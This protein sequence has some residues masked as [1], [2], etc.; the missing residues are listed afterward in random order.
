VT[1]R[2]LERLTAPG[3]I[4]LVATGAAHAPMQAGVL[5]RLEAGG[6]EGPI[7]IV[8]P[9]GGRL[10]DRAAAARIEDLAERPDLGLVLT[11]P[12]E[13]PAAID[14][15]GRRGAR[16]AVVFTPTGGDPAL[17]Q[18]M[19]DAA[20]PHLLRILG[21]GSLGLQMP[22][23]G[24][25]ASFAHLTA[26]PGRIGLISQ[27]GAIAGAM[28]D[29][30]EARDIGF[31]AILAL[32]EMAD[33]DTGDLI[34][35]LAADPDTR[36]ILLYVEA[37]TDAR[38][39]LSAA[40]AAARTKPVIA[41]KARRG[42]GGDAVHDAAF[43]RA[44]IVRVAALEDLF[45]AAEALARQPPLSD[46]RLAILGN[47]GGAA[48]L[49]SDAL[50]AAGG[51]LAALSEET[52]ARLDA[53]LPPGAARSN[54]LDLGD[55]A[56]GARYADALA[57][58]LE[59][60]EADAILVMHFPTGVAPPREIADAVVA[61]HARAPR[62]W[63]PKPVF[64][65][66]LGEARAAEADP[67]LEGAGIPAY[68]TP[69]QAIGGFSHL[70]EHRKAQVALIRTPPAIPGEETPNRSA[71]A[72][73]V[74]QALRAGRSRLT[75]P[76]ARAVLRAYRIPSIET[77][78]AATAAE[79]EAA[80]AALLEAGARSLAVKIVAPGIASKT[81]L[82]GVR[83]DVTTA[84]EARAAAAEVLA[85]AGERRPD[86]CP[87]G[88]AVQPM[89]R[90]SDAI[91]LRAGLEEDPVFGPVVV[92]GTGGTAA[93][94]IGDRAVALPPLDLVLAEDLVSRA[95]VSRLIGGRPGAPAADREAIRLA[96][97]RL[98]QLAAD[99]PEITALDVNPL[100]AG[101]EGVLAL[102]IRIEVAPARPAE[103]GQ[104]PRFALRPYPSAWDRVEEVK[105]RRLRIR[106]IRPE[107]E[108]L[109]PD[110]FARLSAQDMRYRFFG[111]MGRPSHEQIARFTQIDYAR[112]MA[113]VALPAEG[114]EELL[115]V[116]RLATDPDGLEAEFAVIV[117]SDLH[118]RGLGGALMRRLIDYA[119]AEGIET[120]YG[121]V[122]DQ[123]RGMLA[124]CRAL[125]FRET[126]HP[127]DPE[128]QRVVMEFGG[129]GRA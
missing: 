77:R 52:L 36:A 14:A 38:K 68:R 5:A 128:L 34:D 105:G 54:P 78:I 39:F 76:E 11:P 16:A 124:M 87:E 51:R 73:A 23:L 60:K 26:R 27:S 89:A 110:F 106:P 116:S 108:T 22:R 94:A 29:W 99:M 109:Y 18:A 84:P 98:A 96:L 119:R 126:E 53:A 90:A 9:G 20:R 24:L 70:A 31:S 125:G 71:A 58:L 55:D 117:R 82:G 101:P 120:L 37:V 67:V 6:F 91:E 114:D 3:S 17:C 122:L 46:D 95:R 75:E 63:R 59:E 30:A 10:A 79:A 40:R 112:A 57:A 107:D 8:A 64:A 42:A 85:R 12:G 56:D 113:F 72:A 103:P 45:D 44:G 41:V 88:L 111:M 19:L 83:L 102:D 121:D 33:I 2:N 74:A 28:I 47:G 13:V 15:L 32:G 93:E 92:F 129:E 25:D 4:A 118:G 7:R 62:R 1:V 81:E 86:I 80:A 65:A 21:P 43:R 50:D 48:A 66:W 61:A 69:A 49:A 104:N 127:E 100:L 35:H 123:N 115:G 97:V